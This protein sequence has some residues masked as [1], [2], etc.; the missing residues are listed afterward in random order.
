MV[1]TSG[2]IVICQS[3]EKTATTT[4]KAALDAY[5]SKH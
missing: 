2:I 5:A 4:T 1:S 3:E